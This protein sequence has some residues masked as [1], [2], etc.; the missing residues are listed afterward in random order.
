MRRSGSPRTSAGF[1]MIELMVVV[2]IVAIAAGLTVLTMRDPSAT[3]LDREAV[4]LAA[5]L[6]SARSEA[7]ALGLPAR[8]QP[9]PAG[10]ASGDHFRFIGLPPSVQMP[11]HWL[12]EGISA[13]VEGASA[14]RLGP[15]ATIGRQRIVLM[16]EKQ[17][18]VLQTDGIGPFEVADT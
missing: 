12:E 5:L 3:R 16:I 7:R 4:R 13:Q 9:M 15:E 14:V 8:W 17:R 11:T 10:D 18:V 1:T 6:D 2:A